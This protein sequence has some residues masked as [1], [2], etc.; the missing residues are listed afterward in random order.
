MFQNNLSKL[1]YRLPKPK[2]D[3]DFSFK[4]FTDKQLLP[5]IE[6]NKAY[7]VIPSHFRKIKKNISDF[8]IKKNKINLNQFQNFVKKYFILFIVIYPNIKEE[9]EL[10]KQIR[11]EEKL[12]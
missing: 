9:D 3:V 8:E 2:Y 10:E 11:H 5:Q 4:N 6:E 12:K 1:N 7:R